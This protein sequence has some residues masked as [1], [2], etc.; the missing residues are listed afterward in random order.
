[1]YAMSVAE[2]IYPPFGEG[3]AGRVAEALDFCGMTGRVGALPAGIYSAVTREFDDGGVCFSGGE[4]QR[5]ALA[6][7]YA[8]RRPILLLDEPTGNLDAQTEQ[9]IDGRLRRLG[10]E[11][12]EQQTPAER[13]QDGRTVILVTHRLRT[14]QSA[15]LVYCFEKGRLV[16][17]GTPQ[18]LERAGGKYCAMLRQ[19]QENKKSGGSG[20]RKPK[21]RRGDNWK[22]KTKSR[23]QKYWER[24]GQN[25]RLQ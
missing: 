24:T 23:R 9:E 5:L 11:I 19:E 10:A 3:D 17:S 4:E 15:E 12:K 14:A 20:S 22:K 1:I 8:A 2:N 21:E 18:E 6:R 7:A 25:R 13:E 16:E